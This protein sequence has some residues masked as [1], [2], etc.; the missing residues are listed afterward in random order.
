MTAA[1]PSVADLEHE[2]R[3]LVLDRF[4]HEEVWL[5][6][7]RLA[8]RARRDRHPV[9]IDVRRTS[10]VL[11]RAAMAGTTADQDA[12]IDRKSAT[13]FRF[14]ASTLL[15]G[16]RMEADGRDP[17]ADGWL[18]P[19]RYTLAGGAVPIRVA[20]AGVV[21]VATVSGLSSQED[22]ALVVDEVRA[23]AAGLR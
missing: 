13:A 19:S 17:F 11:F 5:L 12:W 10:G 3:E 1:P 14:E 9:M 23:L 16:L 20:G 21:A 22:H 8:E 18:D 4:T 6:G 2:E 15:V 7:S